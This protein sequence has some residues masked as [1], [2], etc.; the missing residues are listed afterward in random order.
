MITRERG[1]AV[2]RAA[3]GCAAVLLGFSLLV[4]GLGLLA[5][6]ACGFDRRCVTSTYPDHCEGSSAVKCEGGKLG[7]GVIRTDCRQSPAGPGTCVELPNPSTDRVPFVTCRTPC[8][9]ES[10][11]ARCDQ[12]LAFSC[13]R[14]RDSDPFEVVVTS[15]NTLVDRCAVSRGTDGLP[16]AECVAK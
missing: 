1:R 14:S 6:R 10:F 5:L 8:D 4:V 13:R 3:R 12:N 7:L 9:P 2:K 11:H 16:T 15:C